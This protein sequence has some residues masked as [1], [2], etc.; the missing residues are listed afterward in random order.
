[1]VNISEEEIKKKGVRIY[2]IDGKKYVSARGISILFKSSGFQISKVTVLLWLKKLG[3]RPDIISPCSILYS[4]D[5]VDEILNKLKQR[6]YEE[7]K[8]PSLSY[9]LPEAKLHDIVNK[10]AK[11]VEEIKKT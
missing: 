9:L 3:V 5:R 1:L 11:L 7:I 6:Y 4:I 2:R 8:P 10:L